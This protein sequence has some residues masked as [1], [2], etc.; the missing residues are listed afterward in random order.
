MEKGK[1]YVLK[2]NSSLLK[3]K[4]SVYALIDINKIDDKHKLVKIGKVHAILIDRIIFSQ[5]FE[6]ITDNLN[7]IFSNFEEISFEEAKQKIDNTQA[8]L[9]KQIFR[10]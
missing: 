6:F 4:N 8:L 7:N 9:S 10:R 1:F 2:E 5:T 3:E